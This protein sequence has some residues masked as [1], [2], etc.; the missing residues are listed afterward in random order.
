PDIDL[1]ASKK[2]LS[3]FGLDDGSITATV[4]GGVPDYEFSLNAGPLQ[5]DP[6][7]ENLSAGSFNLV[8]IDS[9]GCMDS[10]KR[11]L[12]EPPALDLDLM[13]ISPLCPSDTPEGS[14]SAIAT[15]G[16]SPIE[17]ALGN[18]AF[19]GTSE[20]LNLP[21]AVYQVTAQDAAG[22]KVTG[23]VEVEPTLPISLTIPSV[24]TLLLGD[25]VQLL[26]QIDFQPDSILWSPP[27]RLSCYT[28]LEPWAKPV[29]TTDYHLKIWSIEGC[30]VSAI[31]RL[32]VDSEVDFFIPNV[33][34]PNGDNSNDIFTVFARKD[35]AFVH[36]LL[37]F[38][39]WGNGLW[40]NEN[41]VPNGPIGWD[42][43]SRGQSMMAGVYVWLIEIELIDGTRKVLSGDVT[44]VR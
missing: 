42:G 10:L 18:G 44:L 35:V 6:L 40:E 32:E 17:Y 38:D 24:Q 19:S 14:I 27:E 11:D 34:S 23:D 4:S 20:F 25:S 39:R 33:F 2:D 30:L 16:T 26:P 9:R 37:I 28:C 22:C 12:T 43:N 36:R 5:P 41:F 21:P 29:Q 15:G 13:A 1:A 7:F 8:V 3:C 31:V